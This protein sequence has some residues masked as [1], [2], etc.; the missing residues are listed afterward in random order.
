[1]ARFRAV[2]SMEMTTAYK[3]LNEMFVIIKRIK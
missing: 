2:I 3:K 1:M